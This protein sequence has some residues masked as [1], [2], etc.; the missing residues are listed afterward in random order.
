MW[1][2]ALAF[3]EG[4]KVLSF[5]CNLASLEAFSQFVPKTF[6]PLGSH[7][8]PAVHTTHRPPSVTPR[9]SPSDTSPLQP[10]NPPSASASTISAVSPR[11]PLPRPRALTLSA[12]LHI[13]LVS[14]LRPVEG[15]LVRGSVLVSIREGRGP[16]CMRDEEG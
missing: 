3:Y 4:L 13:V 7:N 8:I 1:Q 5:R 6:A 2:F 14:P 15:V 11:N 9:Y 10:H 12:L 16:F